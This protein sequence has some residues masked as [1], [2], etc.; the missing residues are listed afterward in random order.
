MTKLP[1]FEN[2]YYPKING[3][4]ILKKY[5]QESNNPYKLFQQFNSRTES[6]RN[7][8]ISKLGHHNQ[9]IIAHLMMRDCRSSDNKAL[10]KALQLSQKLKCPL[11]SVYVHCLENLKS[12]YMGAFQYNYQMESLEKYKK[13]LYERHG[14]ELFVVEVVRKKHMVSEVIKFFQQVGIGAVFANIEYEVDE[15]R[16]LHG[17]VEQGLKLGIAVQTEQDTCVVE[18]GKVCKKS[19]GGQF[20]VFKPW[21]GEWLKQ[22]KGNKVEDWTFNGK[23]LSLSNEKYHLPEEIPKEFELSKSQIKNFRK[24]EIGEDFAERN[25]KHFVD[26]KLKD[27]NNDSRSLILH[28]TNSGLSHYVSNGIIS[29]RASIRL[30]FNRKNADEEFIRQL[31]WRDFY[32]HTVVAWPF[33]VMGIGMKFDEGGLDWI[34]NKEDFEA[35]CNGQTGVPVIDAIMLE[36]KETG[37]I[38]NRARMIVLSY[39]VKDLLVDWRYGEKYFMQMLVDGDFASNNGGWGFISLFGINSQPWFR[40]LNPWTQSEKFG[41]HAIINKWPQ[42]ENIELQDR[43]VHSERRERALEW[44]HI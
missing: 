1:P 35:W 6:Q 27:Y 11:I 18:P 9:P 42:V 33:I 14:V 43:K 2:P 12:H 10:Y 23:V 16:F 7:E 28:G 4:E 40:V 36:L 44:I 32:K 15:V 25:L 38:T 34:N 31:A 19:D 41:G 13:K 17:L 39:L 21:F 30:Y 5:S 3:L 22:V 29:S 24:Y 37:Y 26:T 20:K 8:I